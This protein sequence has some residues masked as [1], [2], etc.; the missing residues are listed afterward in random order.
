MTHVHWKIS[1][2]ILVKPLNYQHRRSLARRSRGT[3]AQL[4]V[5]LVV[6]PVVRLV[7]ALPMVLH[8]ARP[9]YHFL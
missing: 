9:V 6:L 4:S 5:R 2:H 8:E 1:L 3:M 7:V